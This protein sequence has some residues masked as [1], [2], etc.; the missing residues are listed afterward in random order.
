MVGETSWFF[1]CVY[2]LPFSHYLT[3]EWFPLLF[4]RDEFNDDGN[5]FSTTVDSIHS[6]IFFPYNE[7]FSCECPYM[8]LSL[9]VHR[10]IDD[11]LPQAIRDKG[12]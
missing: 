12:C 10:S 6:Y 3:S 4:D 11:N 9:V 1:G 7:T 5:D 2:S 8:L